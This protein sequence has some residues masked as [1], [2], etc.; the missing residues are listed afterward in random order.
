[1]KKFYIQ[2]LLFSFILMSMNESFSQD[3][4]TFKN[5]TELKVFI[6]YQTKDTLK[7]FLESSPDV[8]YIE[9]LNNIYKIKPVETVNG[10]IPDS[11]RNNED[12]M[13]YLHYKRIT[14][15]G[16]ALMAI[17]AVTGGL[18]VALGFA[19]QDIGPGI[20]AALSIGVGGGLI[21][22][23]IIKTIAGSVKMHKYKDKLKGF[24]FDLKCTPQEQ[25]IVVVYRL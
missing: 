20:I 10:Y 19:A 14:N 1:M 16:I 5:G 9:T 2:F 22:T 24:S 8:V 15:S 23:G 18:G 12:Y 6:T 3:I 4:V 11:L 17:G 13:K 7:Y 21:I 25:G